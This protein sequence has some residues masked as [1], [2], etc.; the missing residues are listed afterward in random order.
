LF[1]GIGKAR[2]AS[3]RDTSIFLFL[4]FVIFFWH[5]YL[6]VPCSNVNVGPH[7]ADIFVLTALCRNDNDNDPKKNSVLGKLISKYIR[8][9]KLIVLA[10]D[11]PFQTIS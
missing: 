5:S 1:Y 9:T 7:F 8:D 6:E 2:N 3:E 10:L 4:F 11:F